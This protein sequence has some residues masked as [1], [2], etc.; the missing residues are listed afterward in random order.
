M[1][2]LKLLIVDSSS[3]QDRLH[4]MLRVSSLSEMA[5]QLLQCQ[6]GHAKYCLCVCACMCACVLANL[7]HVQWP[8]CYLQIMFRLCVVSSVDWVRSTI[9]STDT[10]VIMNKT[11]LWKETQSLPN[12]ST[13]G[14]CAYS[15][16]KYSLEGLCMSV[17]VLHHAGSSHVL[18]VL[19]DSAWSE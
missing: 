19:Q 12:V 3:L 2:D 16:F 1:A 6:S 5:E 4:D 10:L 13:I 14:V 8:L 18:D 11:D 9:G 17:H 15:L 7:S